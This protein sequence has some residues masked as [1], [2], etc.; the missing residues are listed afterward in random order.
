[1]RWLWVMSTWPPPNFFDRRLAGLRPDSTLDLIGGATSS[2]PGQLSR[3]IL[4]WGMGLAGQVLSNSPQTRVFKQ[5][6]DAQQ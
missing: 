1:M 6:L 2:T 4:L 5:S 3:W